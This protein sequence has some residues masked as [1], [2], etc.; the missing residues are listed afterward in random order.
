MDGVSEPD[1]DRG[2]IDGSAPDEVAFVIPGG[3]GTVLA[4]L[5]EGTLDGVALLVGGRV[6]GGW[7]AGRAAAAEPVTGL[8]CGLGDGGL[9][10]APAQV[11]AD[12]A[13]GVGLIAQNPRR[14]GPGPARPAARDGELVHEREKGQRVVALPGAGHPGQ[15]PAPSVGEQVDLGGQPAPRPAQRLPVLVIRPRP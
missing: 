15:R 12:R 9:D 14:P 11:E 5:A 8:I 6:E 3:D 2:D 7:P 13:A 4:E 10:A 1:P